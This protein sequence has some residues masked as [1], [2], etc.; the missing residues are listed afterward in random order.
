MAGDS[1]K[2]LF[3]Q[4]LQEDPDLRDI[5]EEFVRGLPGRMEE[6]R[7]AFDQLDWQQLAMLAHRLKGA[8]GSYGYPDLSALAAAMERGFK[9]QQA[10]DLGQWLGQFEALFDAA[11]AGLSEAK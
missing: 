11:R 7:E 6:I 2:K 9:A 1:P 10:E 3:S 4:L 5:V 8:S